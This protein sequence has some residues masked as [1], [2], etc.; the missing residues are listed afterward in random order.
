M[1]HTLGKQVILLA[2][3]DDDV[4]SDI[5]HIRCI[6]YRLTAP[7]TL[8]TQLFRTLRQVAAGVR[9]V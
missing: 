7:R 2:K 9:T 8:E 6:K 3:A 1:V 4:P 5:R